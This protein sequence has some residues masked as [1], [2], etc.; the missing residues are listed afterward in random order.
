MLSIESGAGALHD[1]PALARAGLAVMGF[2][3]LLDLVAHVGAPVDSV[4]SS[5]ADQA[6]AHL[7]L[8]VGMVLIV[9]GVVVDGVR[10]SRARRARGHPRK[11]VA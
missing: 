3:G 2:G 11:G 6:T 9:L 7:L 1:L 10:L 5:A 8:F 4:A